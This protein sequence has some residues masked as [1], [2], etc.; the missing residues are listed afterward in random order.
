MNRMWRNSG[1]GE[2]RLHR[3][4]ETS[5]P[6]IIPNRE[7]PHALTEGVDKRVLKGKEKH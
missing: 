1:D 4:T 5:P 7:H 2:T 3:F 6:L